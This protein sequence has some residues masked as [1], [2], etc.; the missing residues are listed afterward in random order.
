MSNF[1][2]Q[3]GYGIFSVSESALENVYRY[4]E[5]QE[6]HHR[7]ISFAEEYKRFLEKHSIGFDERYY[8]K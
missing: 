4:I 1:G 5:N 6:E 8:M 3:E 2:W 7:K